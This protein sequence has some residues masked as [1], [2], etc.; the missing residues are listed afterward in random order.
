M[1]GYI[2]NE[3]TH[4]LGRRL[5]SDEERY[6]LLKRVVR[7]GM[8]LDPR[9]QNNRDTPIFFFQVP[10]RDGEERRQN[11]YPDPYFEV[12]ENGPVAAN[13][14]VA[15]EMVCF[16]DIP[17]RDLGIHTSKYSRFGLGFPKAF[18]VRQGASPVHYV[19]RDAATRL[20]LVGRDGEIHPD[21]FERD[22][23]HGL[24]STGQARAE[25]L[26]AL[27]LRTLELLGRHRAGLEARFASYKPGRDDPSVVFQK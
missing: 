4:F 21:F 25:F 14:F 24:L 22:E 9:Y 19:A 17:V 8:L 6:S 5:R 3:L 10:K 16:C 23:G 18:L 2:S 26:E 11:Y 12:R 20:R 15:P 7:S 13:E 27:R 1:Q